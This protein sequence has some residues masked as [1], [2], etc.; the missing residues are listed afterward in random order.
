MR[1]LA[2]LQPEQRF[3]LKDA[4]NNYLLLLYLKKLSQ[5]RI[6]ALCEKVLMRLPCK[7]ALHS[8]VIQCSELYREKGGIGLSWQVGNS[9]CSHWHG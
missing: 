2:R 6:P 3:V 5:T 1:S 7:E 8:P 9:H 4:T